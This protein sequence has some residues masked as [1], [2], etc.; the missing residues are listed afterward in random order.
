VKIH[1]RRS[2]I[3]L[4]VYFTYT[5][6]LACILPLRAP[7]PIVTVGINVLIL[8][9]LLLLAAV[10]GQG[11][12]TLLLGLRGF[13]PL[14]LVLLAYREMGWF[15]RT[16]ASH[17]LENSWIRLDRVILPVMQPAI[18]CF[19][20]VIPSMLEIAYSLASPTP[21]AALIILS[22][23]KRQDR[24]DAF[25]FSFLLG[26]FMSYSMFPYFPSEPPRTIF[27]LD[28]VPSFNT[29][30]RQ[31]NFDLLSGHGIHTSVFPSAHVSAGF[32]AAIGLWSALPKSTWLWGS[33]FVLASLI[34]TAT[35]YGRY[36]YAV[37]ALAGL[38][39][40]GLTL[41]IT[42]YLKPKEPKSGMR[43]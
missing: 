12:S 16:M 14:P 6:V 7:I 27:P 15:A 31:F 23:M 33:F 28:N 36:H 32:G 13:F 2:E 40:S 5:S 39:V 11:N 41:A 29:V 25:W 24:L 35:V 37:D 22:A 26:A 4:I 10:E 34:T 1:L 20:P 3:V 19:G 42:I 8:A 18:E 17:D 30:F 9:G 43:R 21:L 38:G